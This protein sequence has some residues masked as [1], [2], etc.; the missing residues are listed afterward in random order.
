MKAR[1]E[2]DFVVAKLEDGED[3]LASL[4]AI[5]KANRIESGTVLW[6]IGMVRDFEVGFF[7]G[8]EYRRTT[9]EKPH[10]LLALHGSITVRADP[11]FHLHLAAGNEEKGV[12]GGHLFKATVAVLN[13]VCLRRFLTIRMN[14]AHNPKS[15]LRELVLE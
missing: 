4:A 5:V 9:F 14:R 15:G 2:G 10:E 13:E 1:A 8:K 11:M 7:G 6:G 3:L 12:V